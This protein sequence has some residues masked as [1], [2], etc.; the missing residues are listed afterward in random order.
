MPS[1]I[2]APERNGKDIVVLSFV[3]IALII[4]Y[5]LLRIVTLNH[6][7]QQ[8]IETDRNAE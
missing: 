7:I 3:L 6:F 4:V 5:L 1:R 8:I 2:V